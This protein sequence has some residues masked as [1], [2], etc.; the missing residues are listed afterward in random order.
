MA[1]DTYTNLQIE[2]ALW[3]NRQDLVAQIPTFV[4][5]LEAQVE[6]DPKMRVREMIV[7][8]VATTEL[9]FTLLPTDFLALHNIQLNTS[10]R[11]TPLYAATMAE[12]DEVR[13]ANP[14][15]GTPTR[16]CIVGSSIELAPVPTEEVQVEITYYQRI[17]ALNDTTQTTNWMLDRHPGLYLYGSLLQAEP[18]L[19]NDERIT[20]WLAAYQGLVD[21]IDLSNEQATKGKGPINARLRTSY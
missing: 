10:P 4:R 7:R 6:S 12:V 20:V 9:E 15:G 18:Y 16:F 13:K 1:L 17:P 19:K 3:L 21:N 2:I 5:L 14:Q 11:V 8:A